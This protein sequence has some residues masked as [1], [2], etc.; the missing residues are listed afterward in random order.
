[1]FFAGASTVF[2]R[3]GPDCRPVSG[4]ALLWTDA[5]LTGICLRGRQ[6]VDALRLCRSIC[7][8]QAAHSRFL[9]DALA[10]FDRTFLSNVL[11]REPRFGLGDG[12]AG[13]QTAPLRRR[14]FVRG[15]VETKLRKDLAGGAG[16]KR[17]EQ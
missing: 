11:P 2:D 4:A 12:R 8:P 13:L 6:F 10:A 16:E 1:G 15:R 17:P 7:A 9:H 14:E 5:S 3:A